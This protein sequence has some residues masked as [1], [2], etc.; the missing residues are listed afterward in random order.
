MALNCG[1][2]GMPNVG[3]STI[4]SALTAVQVPAESYPFCT[5]QEN[6]GVVRVPDPRLRKI[7]EIMKP[8]EEVPA[9]MR[10]VDIA[11]LVEGASRGE[12]LGNRF[13]GAVRESGVI[14]HVVRCFDD[15]DVPFAQGSKGG[16]A[17]IQVVDTE[18]ALADLETI[19]RRL[20][21]EGRRG[22]DPDMLALYDRTARG[23]DDGKP[24]RTLVKDRSEREQLSDLNLLSMKE[25]LYVCNVL[26]DTVGEETSCVREVRDYA[27]EYTQAPGDP[28]VVRDRVVVLSGKIEAEIALLE[29]PG[30]RKVFLE[31]SGLKESGLD[32][33]IRSAYHLL[34]LKT[35]FTVNEKEAH[36]WTLRGGSTAYDA[37]AKVHTDF[38]RGFI[39][40][41]V[42]HCSDLFEQGS[43]KA[44]R[45]AGKYRT[46]GR[47]YTV[48]DGDIIFFKANP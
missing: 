42:Y 31:E 38:Q 37:A 19:Q 45:E 35:F 44:V 28:E 15:P 27:G 3:K 9:T 11:G 21:K 22:L 34:E 10:F 4:F 5:I 14:A 25:Q 46:E 16:V 12:G 29:D 47:E 39:K 18:L 1:I 26:E 13:L 17:D 43:E 40:A 24:A 2:V 41:E 8:E 7:F 33:L 6:I 32:R 36:A 23:L 20:D 30:E 48:Q